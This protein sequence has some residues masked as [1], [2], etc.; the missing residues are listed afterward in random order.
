MFEPGRRILL[1]VLVVVC[2]TTSGCAR[3]D[4]A[5]VS[6]TPKKIAD[7]ATSAPRVA[8]TAS[9]ATWR[10]HTAIS[11]EVV[12]DQGK[13]LLVLGGLVDAHG[14][15][16]DVLKIDPS[17]GKPTK[18]GTLAEGTHD[19]AGAQIG[20]TS[21]VFGGGASSV[22]D[23]V[24]G[25]VPGHPVAIAGHLPQPRADLVTV[26]IGRSV[27][28]IGGYDGKAL[29]APILETTDGKIFRQLASLPI[30]VRY[31]AAASIGRRIFVF[32]G[33]LQ[34]GS[35]SDAI[36]L[37]DTQKASAKIIGRLPFAFGHASAFDIGG[38]IYV[39]GGKQKAAIDNV[40]K[41]DPKSSSV[42]PFARL[43]RPISDAGGVVHQG[44]AYLLGGEDQQPLTSVALLG[45]VLKPTS[46]FSGQMLIADRGNNRLRIVDPSKR[47][48][49]SFPSQTMP[50]PAGGFYFPDD[51]FFV[52]HGRSIISNQEGN[53]TIAQI[54]YPSGK[55]L[56]DY[57]HPRHAGGG[58]GYLNEP[59]DAY[60]LKD[61]R[62]TVADA[63]NCRVLFIDKASG[64]TSQIG[65]TGRCKR[66]AGTL[67][68][69]NGDTPLDNGDFLISE[70]SGS[71][72]DEMTSAGQ[73]IWTVHLPAVKYPSDPQQL[74]A[75]DYLMVDYSKPGA[76][77]E[78][79]REGKILWS[80]RP[81]SGPG[82]L[83]HP[84]LAERLP[85]GLIGVNDDYRHRMLLIDPKSNEIVWQYGTT[86]V[87]GDSDGM[88]N[89]PDGFDIREADGTAPTHPSTG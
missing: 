48:A 39:A 3:P 5:S 58:P 2:L 74:G 19:A 13:S 83:D 81:G 86:D 47:L 49:W 11:R 71:F 65:K 24:Q 43:P 44:I 36:Q 22:S 41:F 42:A 1:A 88:L 61:G 32:G 33:E 31:P 73:V 29:L 46:V 27:Y 14:T 30:P 17:D 80:Y 52:D 16:A 7:L 26:A 45:E 56:W 15:T 53:H 38:E 62:V 18:I 57:G 82:M 28:L 50:A 34:D 20:T 25:F 54:E 40:W 55:I 89:T 4:R 12:I 77:L 69:P 37:I 35:P 66:G 60:L 72:V 67:G 23:A 78:F 6:T 51:A 84:S 76:I 68:Y 64:A 70:I 59:D 9:S 63:R 8:V 75:D 10:L 21:F 79:T 85:N 87:P